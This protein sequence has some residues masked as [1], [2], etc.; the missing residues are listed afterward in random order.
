MLSKG[1]AVPATGCA[2]YKVCKLQAVLGTG[3]AQCKQLLAVQMTGCARERVCRNRLC[4]EHTLPGAG[5]CTATDRLCKV[6]AVQSTGCAQCMR[7]KVETVQAA[8]CERCD[9]ILHGADCATVQSAECRLCTVKTKR[10]NA[11]ARHANRPKY[12]LCKGQA[13]HGAD[14]EMTR[15]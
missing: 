11:A 2:R 7:C 1:Q 12:R 14:R 8:G 13:M 5:S 15:L 10:C 9:C 3:C 4:T 6:R